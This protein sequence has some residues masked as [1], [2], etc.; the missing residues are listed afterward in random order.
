MSNE[1][2]GEWGRRLS[3]RGIHS[4]RQM[5]DAVSAVTGEGISQGTMHRL[6][7][8][9]A[10][11]AE[12]VNTVADALFGGDRDL[13]WRLRGSSRQDH[14][15][16]S[17]PA[18]ASLLNKDQRNAI[19]AVIRAMVPAEQEGGGE[20]D[21]SAATSKPTSGSEIRFSQTTGESIGLPE[22]MRRP[23]DDAAR[24]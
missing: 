16:W 20:H 4:Y 17:L 5:A 19:L 18:D 23:P 8:G 12:T 1:L 21:R 3:P 7:V 22:E 24:S 15:D 11:S 13:V 10:T 6:V 14:G 2:P 9:K